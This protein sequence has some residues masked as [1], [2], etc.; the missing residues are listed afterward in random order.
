M[1]PKRLPSSAD[2]TFPD[3]RGGL[4]KVSFFHRKVTIKRQDGG[5]THHFK[6]PRVMLKQTAPPH[7]KKRQI[8][9]KKKQQI[10]VT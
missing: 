8:H 4:R 5:L 9:R 2:N 7:K 3:A 10:P 6:L 1:T